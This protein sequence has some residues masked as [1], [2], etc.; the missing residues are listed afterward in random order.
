MRFTRASRV[1]LPARA[2]VYRT[3]SPDVT[4]FCDE[5][6]SCESRGAVHQRTCVCFLPQGIVLCVCT[7]AR[8]VCIMARQSMNN[9]K[10][11]LRVPIIYTGLSIYLAYPSGHCLEH[12]SSLLRSTKH[13]S[14]CFFLPVDFVLQNA[15][16][17]IRSLSKQEAMSPEN[18]VRHGTREQDLFDSVPM[19]FFIAPS[20]SGP[21]R[22]HLSGVRWSVN[23]RE[24]T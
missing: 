3:Q 20:R 14:I 16:R 17:C 12:A 13:V 18:K 2:C 7:P 23:S 4:M 24:A 8:C 15:P 1:V 21:K 10:G 5:D 22:H 9:Q 11:R 19:S 6:K